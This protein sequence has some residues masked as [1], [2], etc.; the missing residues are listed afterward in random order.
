MPCQFYLPYISQIYPPPLFVS[1]AIT[2]TRFNIISSLD[3]ATLSQPVSKL[4][5]LLNSTDWYYYFG[6]CH[7]FAENSS[8]AFNCT[9]KNQTTVSDQT[10]SRTQPSIIRWMN[11]C[12]QFTRLSLKLCSFLNLYL[13]SQR[14]SSLTAKN[15]V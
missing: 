12:G 13:L 7:F 8:K 3:C 6:S 9:L 10:I 15:S 14:R 11:K 4:L 5:P 1:T 2:L